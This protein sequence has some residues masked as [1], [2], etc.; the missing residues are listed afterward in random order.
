MEAERAMRALLAIVLY[1]LVALGGLTVGYLT[2]A[3]A[4]DFER[5]RAREE[6]LHHAPSFAEELAEMEAAARFLAVE[7]RRATLARGLVFRGRRG[8]GL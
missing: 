3:P 2:T 6:R 4:I 5:P 7:E 1:G 8:G